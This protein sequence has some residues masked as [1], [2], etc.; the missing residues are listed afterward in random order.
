[1]SHDSPFARASVE[2]NFDSE[3]LPDL[4]CPV[5]RKLIMPGFVY[6]ET[7]TSGDGIDYDAI[8]TVMFVFVAGEPIYTSNL[9]D[10]AIVQKRSEMRTEGQIAEDDELDAFAAITEHLDLGPAPLVL[11]IT[12][13]GNRDSGVFIGLDLV[14]PIEEAE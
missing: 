2:L 14:A 7:T 6:Y 10:E 13:D 5:T 11:N 12:W 1:M 9:T 3:N 4:Y 8:E